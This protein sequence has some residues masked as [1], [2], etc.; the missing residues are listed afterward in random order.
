[1]STLSIVIAKERV[2]GAE[3]AEME[4]GEALDRYCETTGS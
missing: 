4:A 1:M 2:M 3:A